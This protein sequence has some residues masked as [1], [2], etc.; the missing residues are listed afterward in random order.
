MASF[1][2]RLYQRSPA[3]LLRAY[4]QELTRLDMF[5]ARISNRVTTRCRLILSSHQSIANI[6]VPQSRMENVDDAEITSPVLANDI[7]NV[8]RAWTSHSAAMPIWLEL[9][10]Q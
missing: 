1:D 5:V 3:G 9:E 7:A 2:G 6:S 10:R 4:L 8:T